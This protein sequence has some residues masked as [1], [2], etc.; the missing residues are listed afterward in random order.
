MQRVPITYLKAVSQ[1]VLERLPVG[2][3]LLQLVG[4]SVEACFVRKKT[5]DGK[6][7]GEIRFKALEVPGFAEGSGL[8]CLQRRKVLGVLSRVLFGGRK[9]VKS[10]R[11]R[12]R[13]WQVITGV[14]GMGSEGD[15]CMARGNKH[16]VPMGRRQ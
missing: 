10:G 1:P 4:G 7:L 6:G 16:W 13:K 12:G 11:M 3:L 2:L 9:R 14:C 5:A 8:G 15:V